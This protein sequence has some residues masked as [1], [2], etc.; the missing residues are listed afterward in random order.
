MKVRRRILFT[1]SMALLA[2]FC[3]SAISRLLF[4]ARAERGV[5]V[6]RELRAENSVCGGTRRRR[7]TCTKFFAAV[8]LRAAGGLQSIP[9]NAGYA[10]SYD[11][12]LSRAV[13]H[14][15]DRV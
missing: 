8:E 4:L 2:V 7:G 14:V 9:F 12:P 10:M 13:Y 11:Q 6:V 5:G 1:I 3:Y 15:G